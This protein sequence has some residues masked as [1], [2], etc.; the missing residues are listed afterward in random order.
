MKKFFMILIQ[1]VR[2]WIWAFNCILKLNNLAY[3]NSLTQ[4]EIV[5]KGATM[6]N[7]P[8]TPISMR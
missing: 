1:L 6:M 7:G 3:L 2:I 5:D 8:G 4:L